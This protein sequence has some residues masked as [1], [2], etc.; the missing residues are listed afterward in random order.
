MH[1]VTL[2]SRDPDRASDIATSTGASRGAAHA[3]AAAL[4][5]LAVPWEAVEETLDQLG[6]LKWTGSPSPC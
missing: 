5:I 2:G 3:A 6:D 4:V 1:A